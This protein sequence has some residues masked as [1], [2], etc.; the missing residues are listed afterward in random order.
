MRTD[1]TKRRRQ[2]GY[3]LLEYCAGAAIIASVLWVSLN[4]LGES[5]SGILEG[6]ATWAET[7]AADIGTGTGSGSN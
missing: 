4:H 6:V 3:A 5:L 2:R 1:G 7:R